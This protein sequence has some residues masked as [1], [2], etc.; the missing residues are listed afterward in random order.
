MGRHLLLTGA[1]GTLGRWLAP[2]LAGRGYRV[3]LSDI[4]PFPDPLPEGAAFVPA[5]LADGAAVAALAEGVDTILHFG[6]VSVERPW[7]E[8]VGPNIIGVTN[9]F[10]AARKTRARV[11]FASSN[12]TIGFHRRD[13]MLDTTDPCR[14]DGYYGLSKIYGEMLGRMMADKHGVESVHLRIGS[15]LPAPT[16][17]RHLSTWLSLPDLLRAL[18]AAIEAPAA[19]HAVVWGVSAN[20]AR[21]WRGDDAGRIGFAPQDDAASFGPL[22]EQGDAIARLYQGGSFTSQDYDREDGDD[23]A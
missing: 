22:P 21:W 5:D 8:I 23:R 19:G 7:P 20:G 18:V 14:P 11:I 17:A 3:R 2:A 9:I 10:E 6:G 16:E 4:A 15:A 1:S 13:R 12:H